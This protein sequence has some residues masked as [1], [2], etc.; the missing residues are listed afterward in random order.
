MSNHDQHR[1]EW[2]AEPP[3]TLQDLVP[4]V[5]YAVEVEVE[6]EEDE[7]SSSSSYSP[8]FQV[9]HRRRRPDTPPSRRLGRSALDEN[10]PLLLGNYPSLVDEPTVFKRSWNSLKT[11]ASSL[12]QNWNLNQQYQS[13]NTNR[14]TDQST[15]STGPS[16]A[17][18]VSTWC[19][20]TWVV[21]TR[22]V[23]AGGR[24]L[25]EG[26]DQTVDYVNERYS[27]AE[28]QNLGIFFAIVIALYLLGIMIIYS[29]SHPSPP[30]VIPPDTDLPPPPPTDPDFPVPPP[31]LEPSPLC[32]TKEC[33]LESASILNALDTSVDPCEDF[34]TFSCGGWINSHPIPA[35]ASKE[36]V[37]TVM[38]AKNNNILKSLL[39]QSTN[40]PPSD[41][42][43]VK[44]FAKL[45][46]LYQ[47]CI[48]TPSSSQTLTDQLTS[49]IKTFMLPKT[50][51]I[52]NTFP[53]GK[54]M[55]R[56]QNLAELIVAAQEMGLSSLFTI[57]VVANPQNPSA[58][59]TTI[60]PW[61]TATLGL[62]RK[63]LY[64]NETLL[65]VYE[66]AVSK[67]L[68]RVL[69]GVA[70]GRDWGK[71]AKQVVWFE[72]ELAKIIP[73]AQDLFG[74][75]DTL[76]KLTT[77]QTSSSFLSWSYYYRLSTGQ[78][79]PRD[80]VVPSLAYF[81]NLSSLITDLRA[82]EAI[83]G[84][85]FWQA[86][87]KW[88]KYAGRELRQDLS[89]LKYAHEAGCL[90]AVVDGMSDAAGRWFVEHS[91]NKE[92]GKEVEAVVQSIL[93]S[94][95]IALP[96]YTW[97]DMPTISEAQ[98]KLA[99]MIVTAG[100]N[101]KLLDAERLAYRYAPLNPR[102]DEWLSNLIAAKQTS[103]KWKLGRLDEPVDP[104]EMEYP[105]TSV[106]G[107]YT[108]ECF[109]A[110]YSNYTSA[111]V[112]LNG[113]LTLDENMADNAGLLRA[114][115]AW[116]VDRGG[117]GGGLRNQELAG[118]NQD[119]SEQ[120]LFFI[121]YA[122]M[123]CSN[124]RDEALR[125]EVFTNPHAPAEW[126]VKGVMRNS[127]EF[128]KAF[129]CPVGS[130]MNPM[131]KCKAAHVEKE[132]GI[133]DPLPSI[134]QTVDTYVQS[135]ANEVPTAN[136][137]RRAVCFADD[138]LNDQETDGNGANASQL[139]QPVQ[140]KL[141]F[142]NEVQLDTTNLADNL[143]KDETRLETSQI[144]QVPTSNFTFTLL[145][146]VTT[147]E[148]LKPMSP[149][150]LNT[151]AEVATPLIHTYFA[152]HG[153]T[154]RIVVGL[155]VPHAHV[156]VLSNP[157][158][159]EFIVSTICSFHTYTHIGIDCEFVHNIASTIQIAF[160]ADLIVIFQFVV[161]SAITAT[162]V[163]VLAPVAPWDKYRP[164]FTEY[165][166]S[167]GGGDNGIVCEVYP[168]AGHAWSVTNNN[169]FGNA[170]H[171]QINRKSS[172]GMP[173]Q[174]FEEAFLRM[175]LYKVRA[176]QAP[177]FYLMDCMME[178][179]KDATR[180]VWPEEKKKMIPL[181]RQLFETTKKD[182]RLFLCAEMVTVWIVNEDITGVHF[183]DKT[184]IG[185]PNCVFSSGMQRVRA[186]VL[187]RINGKQMWKCSGC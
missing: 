71:M 36:S 50:P 133:V 140:K 164:C 110:Q 126:R 108:A 83:D 18:T 26:W 104:R 186:R 93:S 62:G 75:D 42:T 12:L 151:A 99:A 148:P 109:V 115:E 33:V 97:L 129:Q 153:Y 25:N 24:R 63:D 30:V 57:G 28:K 141:R 169:A 52:V 181:I 5:K 47:S 55:L 179:W 61:E 37:M 53:V 137:K 27:P 94:F 161:L 125:K 68:E 122:Q 91:F 183:G 96:K 184:H 80:V 15:G 107:A 98:K 100:Y 35:S 92:T 84:Y 85:F 8:V 185:E 39:T 21:V 155:L 4:A 49:H 14:S 67:G 11:S 81:Q 112:P 135:E 2:S 114:Y 70:K 150:L 3:P 142:D 76:T 147:E 177:L 134:T 152:S 145:P 17:Q 86:I 38:N 105:I 20:D 48:S 22:Q 44:T 119:F 120:Q 176:A 7:A 118:L 43:S 102:P 182:M 79:P 174:L 87:W 103:A 123:E 144:P 9:S 162:P 16:T 51:I 178:N 65:R 88:S 45:K 130:K 23:A 139:D 41:P 131:K 95:S 132:P 159:M 138:D 175:I 111:D 56:S 66:R 82:T 146:T 54:P 6:V 127:V 180:F 157:M 136:K 143:A 31:V 46:T 106:N 171:S 101:P 72:G 77:L 13:L 124:I 117:K 160:A 78:K 158:E 58:K 60:L 156:Y 173:P 69:G 172:G 163:E 116:S 59:T 64:K 40:P 19:K 149:L 187:E 154:P 168:G 34:Y 113:K 170:V 10:S 165:V 121:G 89:E 73:S 1:N 74:D 90:S 128:A 166:G 167:E 29:P 32:T